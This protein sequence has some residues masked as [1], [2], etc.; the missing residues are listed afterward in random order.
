MMEMVVRN[1]ELVEYCPH[2]VMVNCI[3]CF[4]QIHMKRMWESSPSWHLKASAVFSVRRTSWHPTGPNLLL[5]PSDS[6]CLK[7][8]CTTIKLTIFDVVSFRHMPLQLL[9][10]CLSPFP[11]YRF[12]IFWMLHVSI[13]KFVLVWYSPM[14]LVRK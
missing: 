13:W 8:Q 11:L 2:C 12:I 7:S 5:G 10:F 3:K 4:H 14:M 6:K 1:S 9:I